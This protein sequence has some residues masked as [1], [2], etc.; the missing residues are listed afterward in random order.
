MSFI[1]KALKLDRFE[2][3][4]IVTSNIVT[5]FTLAILRGLACLYALVV[6]ISVW[7]TSDTAAGYFV[8][9][10]NL[11]YFGLTSYL[12]CSTLWS[13]GYL[14]QPESDRAQWLKSG[15]PW[16]GY[17]H[18]LLYATIITFH[19]VVP[20]VF[21]TLLAK[22]LPTG[23]GAWQNASVHAVD[24]VFAIF[25]LI[26]NRHFLQ[27]IHSFVVAGV[28]VLYM[29]LTF[30]YHKTSGNWV[31]PF[32]DWSQGPIAAA[33]YIGIAIGLFIIYFVLLVLHKYRNKWLAG[34]C[35]KVNRGYLE[36][37]EHNESHD[38]EKA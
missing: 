27:P 34:R 15:S 28:M 20:I 32:L 4:R 23:F 36:S 5:P 14:R 24:G 8:F 7:A 9:F 33:Y 16:W 2:P 18:W 29:F 38:E 22:N 25:E 13:F 12:V 1:V 10:T 37:I 3:D 19:V 30:I 35:A 11:T 6:I 17:T 26:F 31:Y 21:W